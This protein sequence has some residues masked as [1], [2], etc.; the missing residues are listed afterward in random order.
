MTGN[1]SANM[2]AEIPTDPHVRRGWV[3]FQLKLRGESYAS[4]G[5]RLGVNRKSVRQAL[6]EPSFEIE[7][8]LARAL[9]LTPRQLFPERYDARGRRIHMVRGSARRRN[10]APSGMEVQ[11]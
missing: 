9:D 10:E 1:E 2:T 3:L 7:K 4:I 11:A 8:A 6:S 5:A